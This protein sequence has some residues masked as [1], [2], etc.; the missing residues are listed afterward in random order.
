MD[1]IQNLKRIRERIVEAAL[2]V[3]REPKN[4][5]LV[6]VTKNVTVEKIIEAAKAGIDTFG[7]NYAQEFRDKYIKVEKALGRDVKWHFIGRIQKNKVKYIVSNVEL[8]HSLDSIKIAEEINRRAERLGINVPVLIEVNADEAY[9]GGVKAEAAE[10]FLETLNNYP[11]ITV[12]GLMTMPPFFEE[13]EMT[14]PYFNSLRKLRDKL[15]K[16]S[17]KI[18]ELSMGMSGDF[19]VAIEEGATILRIGTDIFGERTN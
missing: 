9:K 1:I 19:V 6:A 8:I 3:Q 16:K 15:Q 4:I 17:S 12:K 5:R 18:I 10:E 14:R 2:R 13:K 7:E 11:N